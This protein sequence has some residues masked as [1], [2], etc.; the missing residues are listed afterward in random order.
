MSNK[1]FHKF[2]FAGLL[3]ALLLIPAGEIN[4]QCFASGDCDGNGHALTVS[5][6][7]YLIRYLQGNGPAPTPLYEADLNGDCVLDDADAE[8]YA[9]V[10][11]HGMICLP[12]Y[13]VPTCC[14]P[15]TVVGA[16]CDSVGGCSVRSPA[17]CLERGG[18]YQG[19]FRRCY[20]YSPCVV[21]GDVDQSG[22]IDISDVVYLVSCIFICDPIPAEAEV[23]CDGIIDISDVVYLVMYI[24]GGGPAPCGG[25]K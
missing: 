9:C 20:P 24:F 1:R 22:D 25:C 7:V 3:A 11:E 8:L 21:C 19:D 5:D 6:M 13:P 18:T 10:F 17:H 15:D 16:C 23:N 14:E 4:A 2:I 12:H